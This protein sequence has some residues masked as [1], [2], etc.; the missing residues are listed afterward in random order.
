MNCLEDL[1]QLMYVGKSLHIKEKRG[2]Y[3]Y[4]IHPALFASEGVPKMFI[5]NDFCVEN[6]H[7]SATSDSQSYQDKSLIRSV[8]MLSLLYAMYLCRMLSPMLS[9]WAIITAGEI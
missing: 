1:D 4:S 5:V 6:I 8:S 9:L 7:N 3:H 2:P